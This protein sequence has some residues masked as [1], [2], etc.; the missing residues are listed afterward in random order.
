MKVLMYGNRKMSPIAFDAS[1]PE[2]E[3]KAFLR[4]FQ[5]FDGDYWRMYKASPLTGKQ[6]DWYEKAKYGADG[7]SARKLLT[8]RRTYEYEEWQLVEVQES[9]AKD[10]FRQAKVENA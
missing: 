5:Y 2:L 7:D 1:T 3:L 9:E 8:A 4:L 6:K 10:M